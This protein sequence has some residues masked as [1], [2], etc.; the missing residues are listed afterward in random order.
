MTTYTGERDSA[1]VTSQKRH[2]SAHRDD[3]PLRS[4]R[5]LKRVTQVGVY[6]AIFALV[7]VDFFVL[8]HS[9]GQESVNLVLV[10]SVAT[11]AIE[12]AFGQMFKMRKR[13]SYPGV[14]FME[15][16]SQA[17]AADAASTALTITRQLFGAD[18]CFIAATEDNRMQ[19]L[20]AEGVST[21]VSEKY[22]TQDETREAISEMRTAHAP[23]GDPSHGLLVMAPIIA[24][25]R[26]LGV[27]GIIS[28]KMT[29]D[30]RDSELLIAIGTA[31][32]MSLENIWQRER[33]QEGLSIL[34]TTLDATE[35]GILVINAAG[36]IANFNSR[37]QEMWSIPDYVLKGGMG[38][39]AVTYVLNQLEDPDDFVRQ[40]DQ[41]IDKVEFESSGTVNFKDGRVLELHCRPHRRNEEVVGRV[42]SFSDVT[43]RK[44]SEEMIRHLAYHD[45]LT[46]LPNRSLFA[47]RLTVALAQA[48]RTAQGLAV[49]FLDIDR[50]K[51]INDT[52]GHSAGDELL[53]DLA[54]QLS[55]L[56][57]E[58]DTVARVGGDEFTLLLTGI[59]GHSE[60][61]T[62]AKRVL[63]TV[64]GPRSISGQKVTVTTSIG[65]AVFPRDGD[66]V[67]TLLSN[68]DTAMYRAKQSG[69]NCH[70]TY[71]PAMSAAI[72]DRASL[73]SEL[74]QA[75]ANHEFVV[76]YQPQIEAATGRITGAEAL[77]RW[78]HAERG[79]IQPAKFIDVAEETGLIIPLG[80]W[81]L[82]VACEQN[83]AWQD[84]G[85]PPLVVTVNL[86][87]RQFQ[88][89]DLA[90][91]ISR[92]LQATGLTPSQLELEITEG[93]TIQNPD[94]A[95]SVLRQLRD[96]GVRVSIDDFGTGYSS[97]SYLKRFRL[98]RLKID[99][100][101]V[102]DLIADHN[103]AA[104]TTAMIAMAHS[105]GLTV[106]AE[107]VETEAQLSFLLKH[108]C[109][110]FQGYLMGR[111]VTATEFEGLLEAGAR[112]D[113]PRRNG[114]VG[115]RDVGRS[116]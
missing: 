32:G 111:P 25:Q 99:R 77:V 114:L 20:A 57:R 87:A 112:V 53:R 33:L 69:R 62:I 30:L 40:I 86:A 96:M 14:F 2:S 110:Y 61:E 103:D 83:K 73:E 72:L 41:A 6:G 98:D 108:G 82:R 109:D 63:E 81:V 8:G 104:I 29:P 10:F 70:Q 28:T 39:D 13:N 80:E 48:R 88:Q 106:V 7:P 26:P 75:I 52:L 22:A 115:V 107:G 5:R 47:D 45:A 64:R 1:S 93:T 37:F 56:V 67:Q 105:L 16:G 18:A 89:P 36:E 46:D 17:T 4:I 68:A 90:D 101:F 38:R 19:I 27:L 15:L 60:V 102:D 97:L 42:W 31:V 55:S 85:L 76:H 50:F 91:T 43:E 92:T 12:G 100:S 9:L 74:R 94:F 21:D 65:V 51:L 35:D 54:L 113:I 23:A 44:Q 84:A 79:L 78:N 71:T 66:E 95:A 3:D 34:R 49:M 11:V 59:A 24:W 116:A 58:G